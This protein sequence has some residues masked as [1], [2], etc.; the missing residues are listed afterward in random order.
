MA[1]APFSLSSDGLPLR[2]LTWFEYEAQSWHLGMEGHDRGGFGSDSQED[3][4]NEKDEVES[5]KFG[6]KI[7]TAQTN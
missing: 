6:H 5:E 7:S 2:L 4:F 3:L 1:Q